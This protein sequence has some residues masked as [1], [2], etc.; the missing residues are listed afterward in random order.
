MD[1]DFKYLI[2][3]V[4]LIVYVVKQ[5]M[6]LTSIKSTQ[7]EEPTPSS[8][9]PLR[10][11][12]TTPLPNK[13]NPEPLKKSSRPTISSPMEE[14][15]K[16]MGIERPTKRKDLLTKNASK[17]P[18]QKTYQV[19]DNDPIAVVDYDEN[20][21][22]ELS[23]IEKA[24]KENQLKAERQKISNPSMADEHFDPYSLAKF[25]TSELMKKLHNPQDLRD[26]IILGEILNRKY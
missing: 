6:K 14:L 7:Y 15:M 23:Q 12:N 1:F 21:E 24:K 10:K 25:K 17:Y 8:S 18:S 9:K 20:I 2:W 26:A 4:I 5:I 16:E 22:S 19:A 13:Y 3:G 11:A